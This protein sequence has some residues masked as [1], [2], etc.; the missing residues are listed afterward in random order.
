MDYSVMS[1]EDII[2]DL[3]EQVEKLRIAHHLKE[4]EIEE[5]A[6][7][8]RKTLYNFRQGKGVSLKN[9]VRILRAIGEANRLQRIFPQAKSYSPVAAEESEQVKRVRGKQKPKGG[10]KWGDEM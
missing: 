4:T 9:F 7:V 1:D 8:S 3:A 5:R 6:G 2:R 10:F